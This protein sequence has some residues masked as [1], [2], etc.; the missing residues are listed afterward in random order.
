M[1]LA[2]HIPVGRMTLYIPTCHRS[3]IASVVYLSH[4]AMVQFALVDVVTHELRLAVNGSYVDPDKLCTK[5]RQ[6]S[7]N[8]RSVTTAPQRQFN[9]VWSVYSSLF[10]N[11]NYLMTPSADHP[12]YW[13]GTT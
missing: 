5:V 12:G 9:Q 4:L 8:E 10:I 3:V 13:L 1:S 2:N 11:R 7:P 6:T